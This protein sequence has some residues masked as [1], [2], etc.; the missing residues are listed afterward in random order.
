MA[1]VVDE[2]LK[3]YRVLQEGRVYF[4]ASASFVDSVCIV[5]RY[6]EVVFSKAAGAQSVQRKYAS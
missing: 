2:K 4:G 6:P 1:T 3:A 5:N